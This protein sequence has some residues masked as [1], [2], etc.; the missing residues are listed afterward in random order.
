MER[1]VTTGGG[2]AVRNEKTIVVAAAV[3]AA[4]TRMAAPIVFARDLFEPM[5]VLLPHTRACGMPLVVRRPGAESTALV[6]GLAALVFLTPVRRVLTAP[7]MPFWTL[8]AVWGVVVAAAA[9]VSR[10]A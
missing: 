10:K 7:G 1:C 6:A 8:F 3:T 4:V 2:G 9:W 5:T